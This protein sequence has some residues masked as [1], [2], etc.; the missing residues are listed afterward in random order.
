MQIPNPPDSDPQTTN[1]YSQRDILASTRLGQKWDNIN[2]T[3]H[4]SF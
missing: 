1:K 4:V 2:L 3:I